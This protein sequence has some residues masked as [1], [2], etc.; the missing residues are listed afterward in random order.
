MPGVFT[1][2]DGYEEIVDILDRTE[3]LV[4]LIDEVDDLAHADE[5]G[6]CPNRVERDGHDPF[7]A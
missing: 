5:M 7:L 3:S 1:R 6:G 2:V 4:A